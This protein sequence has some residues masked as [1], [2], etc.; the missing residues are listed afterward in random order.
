MACQTLNFL[1]RNRCCAITAIFCVGLALF[2]P[3]V[4]AQDVESWPVYIIPGSPQVTHLYSDGSELVV[5]TSEVWTVTA[6]QVPGVSVDDLQQY[7]EMHQALLKDGPVT[8]VDRGGRDRSFNIVFNADSSVP[9][10]A[11]TALGIAEAYLEEQFSDNITVT[12]S[13][14]FQNLGSGGIIGAASTQYVN[15]VAYSTCRS[16]LQNGA[17][18][19]DVIEAWLPTG[20]YVP[21]RWNASNTSVSSEYQ[22]DVTRAAYNATIGTVT[23][24]SGS[25][26]FNT[27]MSFDYNPANGCSSGQISFVDVVNHEVGHTLGF[28]SSTDYGMRPKILDLYRFQRTDGSNDYNPDSYAEFQTTPR[29]ID[30]NNPDDQHI[31]DIIDA[32]Y[33]MSDGDPWQGSHFREQSSPWIGLMDPAF[34]YGETHYPDYFSDADKAMFDAIGYDYPACVVGTWVSQPEASQSACPGETVELSVSISSSN[35][36]GYQWRRGSSDV[37][38]DGAHYFGAT[39]DT[40]SI[41]DITSDYADDEYYCEVTNLDEGCSED[42]EL[43]EVIV[44]N[45]VQITSSPEDQTIET[46]DVLQLSVSGS[47]DNPL[48]YQWRKDE[49]DL[50]NG[51]GVVGANTA[52]LLITGMQVEDS[53]EY[54]CVVSNICG[55]V[56]S[57]SATVVV[58]PP[59]FG[60][61]C[62]MGGCYEDLLP[63]DC[64]GGGGTYQGDGTDCDPNPCPQLTG[65]CCYAD[66]SCLIQTEADCTGAGGA[67]EGDDMVCDP[68]PCP[69][70]EGACCYADGSC[71]VQT[72]DDCTGAGGAYEGD[73]TVCD[74][75]PCPQPEGACCYAD[76]SCLIQ[77]EADCIGAGGAYEGD[78]TVCDPN[79]CPQ[80]EGACCY[81]DGSCLIQTE[82]DC[83]GAGGAYEGDDTVCDPNPCPQPEGACCYA[84][85]SCLIQT[86]A[87]CIGAG[88]A[89]EG[90][91]TVCDPN[92][93]PQPEGACCYADGS[94]LIQTEGDCIG[95]GGAYEGDDTVCDPNPCPQPEGACCYAD[96]SC[97]IQTEADCIGAGGAYEGDDTVCDPNPCPQPEGACCYADGSCLIQTE[98]D[99]IGAGG[100]YEG[101]DTVC[102]PNPCPQPEGACC[103][104]DG[105]CLI[106]TEADCIGAGGAYEGDDTVCDPNPCPQPVTG[107]CCHADYTCEVLTA[108]DCAAA[109]GT[110]LGDETVCTDDNGNGL[111]DECECHG[112]ANCD[113]IINFNDID[114]FVAALVAEANWE[115]MFAGTPPCDFLHNDTNWDGNVN[116]NDIDPFVDALVS[117]ICIEKP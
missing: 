110:Y 29:L 10:D 7:S 87:D 57:D 108:D 73:D 104:A 53:G 91:D 89:Y 18:A 38:D 14:S 24:T 69:Q 70:P 107:A 75:N 67:Y 116:F 35:N 68:N 94:C 19:N 109:G 2:A 30:Y 54:D 42:S 86:E 12:L 71:L 61:C 3:P 28:T 85:G 95:A 101:D 36:L 9:S 114:Y 23:G 76:G 1:C 80:P 63:E 15:G 50:D 47:G 46:G 64:T 17:D 34:S 77:T 96:G 39:T 16:G 81:A 8:V 84:D 60:A 44:L 13:I 74:P 6:L 66:G 26:S 79:P 117:G 83:I 25:I 37:V 106:Q 112:D 51:D 52:Y 55:G 72:E 97:L 56:A 65:A 88:G 111:G 113:G 22:I 49:V 82:A 33:R 21:V 5:D 103:Y 20:S 92:P 62:Y 31:S 27:Q 41:V 40:L 59:H 102:D 90:D 48:A 115:A 98:A 58:N 45:G 93:C 100:A 4:A 78:D 32:E 43:A 11:I 99:C 105:S